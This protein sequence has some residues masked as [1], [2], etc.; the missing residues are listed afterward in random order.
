MGARSLRAAYPPILQTIVCTV[1]HFRLLSAI[2]VRIQLSPAL[3]DVLQ[4]GFGTV[5]DSRH[6]WLTIMDSMMASDTGL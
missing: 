1:L 3:P 6:T 5:I 4:R 2:I